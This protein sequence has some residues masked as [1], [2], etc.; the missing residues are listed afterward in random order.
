MESL[1]ILPQ[2]VQLDIHVAAQKIEPY[3]PEVA[4]R[5][6]NPMAEAMFMVGGEP[7]AHEN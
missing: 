6:P 4:L 1:D 2:V 7:K 5:P 3:A